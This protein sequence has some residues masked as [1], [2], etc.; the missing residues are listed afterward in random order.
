[1][2]AGEGT[3]AP[4]GAV[5]ESLSRDASFTDTDDNFADFKLKASPT[6]GMAT[7]A[8]G[9]PNAVLSCPG[10]GT[11][12]QSLSFDASSSTDDGSIVLF[13]F[14]FGDGS[15]ISSGSAS[16]TSHTFATVNTFTVTLTVTDNGGLT[17][18]A[19]C[20]VVVSAPNNPPVAA[21]SCPASGTVGQQLTVN[22]A[23]S[24]DDGTIVTYRF[25]FGDATTPISGPATSANHTYT[26]AATYTV[27]LT[28]T[29]NSG[30]TNT[31]TCSIPVADGSGPTVNFIKPINNKQ[32]TQGETVQILVD[33]TPALGRNVTQVEFFVDGSSIGT[34]TGAPYEINTVVPLSAATSSLIPVVAQATD[35]LGG[36]GISETRNLFVWNDAPQASFVALVTGALEITV[37]ASS[38]S[39]TETATSALEVRWDFDNN[40]TWDTGWSTTKV[41][42]HTYGSAGTYTVAL[43]VRDTT[44]QTD[45]ITHDV[46][47]S[48]IQNVS[49]TVTTT[50]WAGTIVITGDV[51]VPA[52][53][54]LTISEG[55]TV[56]LVATDQ[57]AD[58]VGD[59]DL[60]ILGTLLIN[61][62]STNP[63]IFTTY[64]SG[65]KT[66]KAWNKLRLAGTGNV[67]NWAIIEYGDVGLEIAGTATIGNTEA[68]MN[69]VGVILLAGSNTTW[70]AGSVH[71][72]VEQGLKETAGTF[73][74]DGLEVRDNG[75]SGVYVTGGTMNV[76]NGLVQGNGHCGF[77][78]IGSGTG[79]VTRSLI[80]TNDYEGI[81]IA[82]ANFTDPTPVFNTNNI[83]GNAVVGARVLGTP[84]LTATS[85][86]TSTADASS[87]EWH[88][89]SGELVD[90][91]FA[92]YTEYEAY[93]TSYCSGAAQDW[94][95]GT[96]LYSTT[97][98]RAAWAWTTA[99][100]TGSIRAFVV[101]DQY[102]S[103]GSMN[104][105]LAAYDQL[106]ATREATVLTGAAKVDLK[107]N[108]WGVFPNVLNVLT[109]GEHTDADIQG[110][111]GVPYDSSW[112][113]GPYVGGESLSG[114]VNWSGTIFVTGDLTVPVGATLTVAQ[115]TQVEFAPVDQNVD[116]IGDYSLEVA[117]SLVVSGAS[118]NPVK[119]TTYGTLKAP[120]DW[121]RVQVNGASASSNIQYAVFEY[122]NEGLVLRPGTHVVANTTV[123]QMGT[124]GIQ[125][126]SATSVGLTNIT[127]QDN[128]DDGLWI[129]SCSGVTINRLTSSGNGG[130]GVAAQ[131]STSLLSMT[132]ATITNNSGDGMFLTSSHLS[133]TQST[134]SGNRFGVRYQSG[135]QGTLASSN[136]KFNNR[137][138]IALMSS[139]GTSPNPIVTGNNVFG[140]SVSESGVLVNPSVTA[141]S[142]GTSTAD[143]TS[144]PWSTPGAKTIEYVQYAYTEYE[145]YGTSYCSGYLRKD[146]STGTQLVVTVGALSRYQE[147][148]TPSVTS[149][150]AQVVDDQYDSWGAMSLINVLF[151]NLPTN[152]ELVALND[153]GTVNCTGNYW[154]TFPDVQARMTLTRTNS[155]DYQGMQISEITGTGPQ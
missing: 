107:H 117:G 126:L 112:Q 46:T 5:G 12:A 140:N 122:G 145:A 120:N 38:V 69:R 58:G 15:P 135:S 81:C 150:V 64:G 19:T 105:S 20:Q 138:G 94:A 99:G 89:P 109:L 2:S 14:N 37:D 47:L 155:I 80:T 70:N 115:G 82:S 16:A 53:N 86:G 21:L 95:L 8:N 45:T 57:N 84:N 127:T 125:L 83:Y 26:T 106:G 101:D 42:T 56:Q 97:S 146:N 100:A 87:G 51:T 119:F 62:T 154:G 61:G 90:F 9:A 39:D 153:T 130:D 134:I 34:D 1:M 35:N 143:A 136:V 31:K 48:L 41:T 96:N 110:F 22:G 72:N 123:S 116:L 66:P 13:A 148:A 60:N 124:S 91:V 75:A 77:E 24:T 6:P 129:N 3:P 139:N 92:T 144:T 36:L 54:T 147:V 114:P 17:D 102:D 63:V 93:G 23:G 98:A 74:G 88:T 7:T 43:E 28:V 103:W 152:I 85:S 132:N 121:H 133:V 27:S 141:T 104:L 50:T 11:T 67:I 151:Y 137:E 32:V 33:V 118:L 25:D 68:R 76:T 44:S 113:K 79:L 4:D 111:M 59:Y 18:Q 71:D 49:G 40:G 78:Y 128:L 73:T 149:I 65:N 29:D 55:T 131:S 10:S 142:S 108:Y 52:G 30:L